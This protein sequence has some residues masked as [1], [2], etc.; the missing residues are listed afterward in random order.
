MK[1]ACAIAWLVLAAPLSVATGASALGPSLKWGYE[2]QGTLYAP[3]LVADVH[4]SPGRETIISDAEVRTLRCIDATGKQIWTYRGGWK[5][6]L[7][8]AASLSRTA[9]PGRAT[10]VIGGSDGKLCC[11]DAETGREHWSRQVGGITWGAASWADLDGDGRDEVVAGTEH[12]VIVLDAGGKEVWA[13]RRPKGEPPLEIGTP[14]AICNIDDDGRPELFGAD[15][16]CIFCL[17]DTGM[18]RW[19][20]PCGSGFCCEVVIADADRDGRP[21]LYCGV[22]NEPA[23]VALDARSGSVLWTFPTLAAPSS[24]AVGDLDRDGFEEIVAADGQGHVYALRFDGRQLAWSFQTA[25]RVQ[26][27]VSMGDVDG[28]GDIETLVACWDHCLYC[29]DSAGNPAWRYTADR[30]ILG[31]ATITDVDD[32]GKTDVLFCGSD[33]ILRCITLDGEYDPALIPWPS[34]RFDAAQSG[35]AFP[36][37]MRPP[38]AVITETR[39]LLT[40]GGFERG[41]EAED[42][43]RYPKGSG[44]R[45][46]RLNRPR[47]WHIQPFQCSNPDAACVAWGKASAAWSLDEKTRRSGKR[48][49]RTPGAMCLVSAPVAIEPAVRSVSARVFARGSGASIAS[50]R[51]SGLGGELRLD[52]F[53]RQSEKDG[54]RAFILHEATRPPGARWVTLVCTSHEKGGWWDDAQITATLRFPPKVEVRVNQVGYDVGAPKRF[55][56]QSNFKAGRASFAVLRTDGSQVFAGELEH[57][58][59]IKGHFGHDWGHEFWRGDVSKLDQP[60]RYRIKVTLSCGKELRSVANEIVRHSWPFE[61]GPNLIWDRTARPAYRFFYYQR[62][63]MAVPGYH[64]A[65]HLDDGLTFDGKHYDLSGGWHDAGDYNT[66]HNAPYVYGLAR[67]YGIGK[68]GFDRYD[69]DGNGQADFF[70]EILWGGDHA[71]RM[72]APD[73]S[74]FGRI[75]SGYG[76]WGPP[77]LETDNKPGTGDERPVQPPRPG[78]DSGLHHA[79]LAKISRYVTDKGQ[80]VEAADRGLRWAIKNKKCGV[81]QF[82]AAVDLYAATRDKRYA[83]LARE[84][85]PKI[86]ADEVVI[87]AVRAYDA[88]FGQDHT[89]DLRKVLVARAEQMLSLADNP[90]G[91]LTFGRPDRPNFFNTPAEGSPW[92]VGTNS[93]LCQGATLMALAHQYQP[94]PRYPAFVYDQIN[95][96][97]GNNP[98]GVSLMEGAGSAFVPTYHNRLIF[99]GVDRGAVPGSVINGVTCRDVGVDVPYVDM[100]GV[101]LPFFSSNECWLPHN[102]NYLNALA[103]L[104]ATKR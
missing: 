59:R 60:G 98:C 57:R 50:L 68:A 54:W 82:S 88:L 56:V 23:V 83:D 12:A 78:S 86:T 104:Q 55:N 48:A 66:Y 80:W 87:D 34:S 9:R 69:A 73:G 79:A 22:Q 47:G 39:S 20:R 99:G 24:L 25:K 43:K 18:V 62:C 2:A 85:F 90:F 8:S 11:L 91:V 95:W 36:R 7:T 103:N 89:A 71:R 74:A 53:V 28:D 14:L 49:V 16:C 15:R 10:L 96:I 72:I 13:Y 31:P 52:P 100:T 77:E 46:H 84:L 70:D 6:R 51:W 61:I 101:D 41:K 81:Y 37:A 19:Q 1:H 97:L 29:L 26:A 38:A 63:G 94:D 42:A 21:E 33:H 4:P 17:S 27:E 67:A 93:H 76:F 64:G 30:R 3:P 35:A 58:G 92:R 65:C 44:I 32:D 40:N 102:T 75:T 45:E 5:K